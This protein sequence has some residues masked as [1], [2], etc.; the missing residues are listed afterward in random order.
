MLI[1]AIVFVIIVVAI[2][3][4]VEARHLLGMRCRVQCRV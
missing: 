3:L 2:A 1:I 4:F